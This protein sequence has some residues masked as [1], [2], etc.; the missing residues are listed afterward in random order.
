MLGSGVDD[1]VGRIREF[2]DLAAAK[3][4]DTL[5]IDYSYPPRPGEAGGRGI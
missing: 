3:A 5:T 4:S 1:E 2:D